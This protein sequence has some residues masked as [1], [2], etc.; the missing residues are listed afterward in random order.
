MTSDKGSTAHNNNKAPFFD[1]DNPWYQ[2]ALDEY[3]YKRRSPHFDILAGPFPNQTKKEEVALLV[4]PKKGVNKSVLQMPG[5]MSIYRSH[6]ECVTETL[7][8]HINSERT[9]KFIL[10][11]VE[12][13]NVKS[14][15]EDEA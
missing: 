6:V 12:S 13:G 14:A 11:Q 2:L 10:D 4:A 7:V 5:H 8:G 15:T 9:D 3:N 1:A